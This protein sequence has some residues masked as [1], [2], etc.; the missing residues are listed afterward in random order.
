[1]LIRDD[2]GPTETRVVLCNDVRE[3]AEGEQLNNADDNGNGVRDEMGFNVHRTGNILT[4]RL[5]LE[6]NH[7]QAGTVVRSLSSTIRLR[8]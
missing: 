8:N 1:M 5:T 6:E 2:G 4:L 7:E 3:L